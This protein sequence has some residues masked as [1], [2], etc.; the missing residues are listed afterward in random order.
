MTGYCRQWTTT[1]A[2]AVCALALLPGVCGAYTPGDPEFRAFWV[3][4]WHDGALNQGGVDKM[5]GVP[6]TSSTG[7]IRDAN[8]NAIV[9][10]VR[11]NAD[12]LYP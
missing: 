9:L 1:L 8:C 3:D 5:L 10:Q 7:D 4:A 12:A 2:I 11:R 6:G